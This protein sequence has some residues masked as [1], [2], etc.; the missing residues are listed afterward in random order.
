M[1]QSLTYSLVVTKKIYQNACPATT[2]LAHLVIN[3]REQKTE[4]KKNGAHDIIMYTA[5]FYHTHKSICLTKFL[6]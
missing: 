6:T 1:Y 2:V 5:S 4:Q 3:S